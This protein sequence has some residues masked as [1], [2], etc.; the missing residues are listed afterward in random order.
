MMTSLFLSPSFPNVRFDGLAPPFCLQDPDFA[1]KSVLSSPDQSVVLDIPFVQFIEHAF[2]LFF[3]F[4]T[5]S[6]H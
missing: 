1:L 4:R 3:R 5:A 6:E 2:A